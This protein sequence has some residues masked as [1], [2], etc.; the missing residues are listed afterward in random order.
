MRSFNLKTAVSACLLAC[1]SLSGTAPQ[2]IKPLMQLSQIEPQ[3]ELSM[4]KKLSVG[5]YTN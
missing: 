4:P 3:I 5:Q 2:P 1:A